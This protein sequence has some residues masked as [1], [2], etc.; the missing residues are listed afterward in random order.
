MI[1]RF[2]LAYFLM[3][4]VSGIYDIRMLRSKWTCLLHLWYG[5]GEHS[6]TLHR[7]MTSNISAF[8]PPPIPTV[9]E[10]GRQAI[11]RTKGS[12]EEALRRSCT[13]SF[14]RCHSLS[15]APQPQSHYCPLRFILLLKTNAPIIHHVFSF[16]LP[17]STT[18]T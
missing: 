16:F 7:P 4:S 2:H 17:P 6:A 11:P 3:P 10:R 9:S 14:V 1:T 15:P 13:I 18:P 8:R 12:Y 5:Y